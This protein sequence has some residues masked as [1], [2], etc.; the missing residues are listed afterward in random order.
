MGEVWRA[1][2]KFHL[3]FLSMNNNMTVDRLIS[4]LNRIKSVYGGDSEVKLFY[5][6]DYENPPV[7]DESELSQIVDVM[8]STGYISYMKQKHTPSADSATVFLKYE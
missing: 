1:S 4:I 7:N 5:G 6:C 2:S 3:L 8:V